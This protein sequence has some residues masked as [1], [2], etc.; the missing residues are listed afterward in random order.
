MSCEFITLYIDMYF[1]TICK[2]N[3]KINKLDKEDHI[4]IFVFSSNKKF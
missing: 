2:L 3:Y 4:L 1:R